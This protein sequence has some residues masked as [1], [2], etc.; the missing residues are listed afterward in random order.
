[1][2]I[3]E[4]VEFIEEK[5]HDIIEYKDEFIKYFKKRRVE[6]LV[7]YYF[8]DSYAHIKEDYDLIRDYID[9]VKLEDKTKALSIQ[10]DFYE[11]NWMDKERVESTQNQSDRPCY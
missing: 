3:V 8:F 4:L 6:S 11:L 9:N 10:D 1:M 7:P 2:S 5:K